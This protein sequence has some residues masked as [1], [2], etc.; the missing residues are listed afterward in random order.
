[1]IS[2]LATTYQQSSCTQLAAALRSVQAQSFRDLEI[3]ISSGDAEQANRPELL[4]LCAADPR[5]RMII[6]PAPPQTA[7]QAYTAAF[8]AADAGRPYVMLLAADTK[9]LPESLRH[10]ASALAPP[11]TQ[12]TFG[13][14]LRYSSDGSY[15]RLHRAADAPIEQT[16]LTGILL[17]K[18]C[19]RDCGW[20]DASIAAAEFAESDYT[21]RLLRECTGIDIHRDTATFSHTASDGAEYS[22]ESERVGLAA[23]YFAL[24]DAAKWPLNIENSLAFPVDLLP[25]GD[26]SRDDLRALY[27][28]HIE[29][30][31]R[32][33]Y[34]EKAAE[35]SG[36]LLEQLE[37][38]PQ[39]AAFLKDSEV[40]PEVAAAYRR[41]L[42]LGWARFERNDSELLALRASNAELQQE[43]A[44][45]G[46]ELAALRAD[47][48]AAELAQQLIAANARI[49]LLENILHHNQIE[50]LAFRHRVADRVN[51][52][53]K[54]PPF[55]HGAA[56][57]IV[58]ASKRAA[59]NLQAAFSSR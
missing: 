23:R 14:L 4:E 35:W 45:A 51:S 1:M 10:L 36:R 22:S 7:V 15:R 9:L 26:W 13:N 32:L 6:A 39:S 29:H 37:R 21:R 46:R 44:T 12:F 40:Q 47:T 31:I 49:D 43:V 30:F 19:V 33:G 8:Q 20:L 25:Y 16:R 41:G 38:A 59:D 54:R 24:R 52:L 55:L 27:A 18:A 28:Q 56:K 50:M 5:I 2:I 11:Q 58:R 57:R 48:T 34:V 3:V 42:A 53:L 17:R